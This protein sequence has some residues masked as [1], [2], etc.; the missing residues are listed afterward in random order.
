MVT[1]YELILYYCLGNRPRDAI[2]ELGVSR[3]TAYRYYHHYRQG[4]QALSRHRKSFSAEVY[5]LLEKKVPSVVFVPF[6]CPPT[7]E[8][9]PNRVDAASDE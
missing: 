3:S 4:L 5:R 1:H 8:K 6:W 2:R 9:K 7:R